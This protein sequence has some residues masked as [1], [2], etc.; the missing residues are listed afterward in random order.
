MS[1]YSAVNSSTSDLDLSSSEEGQ[2]QQLKNFANHLL[3]GKLFVGTYCEKRYVEKLGTYRDIVLVNASE[4]EL[5]HNL[6]EV[7]KLIEPQCGLTKW[8]GITEHQNSL[9]LWVSL[10]DQVLGSYWYTV[11]SVKF[12]QSEIYV[13]LTQVRPVEELHDEIVDAEINLNITTMQEVFLQR[14][15]ESLI[16]FYH[17]L[18]FDNIKS[19]TIF[20]SILLVTVV[21]GIVNM[22]KFLIIYT[23][24]FM[25]EI[26]IF[27]NSA[28]PFMQSVLALI[29]RVIGWFFVFFA[30][31]WKDVRQPK[32]QQYYEPSDRMIGYHQRP[33]NMLEYKPKKQEKMTIEEIDY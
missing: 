15:R 33:S 17:L 25:R 24:A 1:K 10:S 28:T 27:V 16:K 21:T 7:K 31:I 13:Q 20:I 5:I 6:N 9:R 3:K 2:Q 26:S 19:S 8:I 14:A 32:K 22:I 29:E 30:M 11:K 4:K 23:L 12:K 18:T